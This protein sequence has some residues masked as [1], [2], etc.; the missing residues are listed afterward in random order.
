MRPLTPTITW[1]LAAVCSTLVALVACSGASRASNGPPALGAGPW[2]SSSAEL[3]LAPDGARL[4]AL[5]PDSGTLTLVDAG[6]LRVQAEVA[7]G[8]EPKALAF[9]PDGALV[10]ATAAGPGR[11]TWVQAASAQTVGELTVGGRP[12]GVVADARRAYVALS[13]RGEIAV[14]DLA[15]RALSGRVAVEPFP[16]G[17]ALG[18]GRLYVTHL[19]TG[20]LTVI[21]LNALTVTRVLALEPEA[22]LAQSAGWAADG[23]RLWLPLTLSHSAEP[24]LRPETAVSPVALGV[25][26][27]ESPAAPT[28][29]DL[30]GPTGSVNLPWAAAPS[31][32]GRWLFVV[33]AGTDDLAV[34]DLTTGRVA[35]RLPVGRSPRGV[36]LAPDG[37]RLFVDHALDGTLGIVDVD[38]QDSAAGPMPRLSQTGVVTLTSLP[39]TPPL[40]EGK[41]LFYSARP[42]LSEGWLSCATCHFDGGHDARTW[43]GVPDGPRNTP[44]LFDAVQT[45]PYHWS[46]DLEDVEQTIQ[47]IQ[48]GAGLLGADAHPPGGAANGG[49]SAALDAL[50]AYLAAL[51]MPAAPAA[52]DPETLGRGAKAFERWGC[53]VCHP[54]PLFTDRR[55][56]QLERDGIG[57]AAL[58]RNPRGL[59]FDTPSLLG[60]WATA[61]YFHDG[62]AATLADTLF[63]AGFH[64]MGWAMDAAERDAVVQYLLSLPLP[65]AAP[66]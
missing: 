33:N 59:R 25:Q 28:R 29:L 5:N 7:V 4:A 49:R 52:A 57:A 62:S 16:A 51:P 39:L 15:S 9:T 46:G 11:V 23:A 20:R 22:N 54:A 8:A 53:A 1:R 6:R 2:R 36:A 47:G 14:I 50:T 56:H 63:R 37:G 41:R 19:Y 48:G 38:Y 61:P 24:I 66:Q 65:D 26:A 18:G 21:D 17:L 3:A 58:Q 35:G 42:P 12:Y 43:L 31:P 27:G 10:L 60:V 40:L 64:G 55:S 30:S 45:A 44:A 13:A 34:L 32:D